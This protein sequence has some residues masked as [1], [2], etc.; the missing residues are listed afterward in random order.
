MT[1]T[2]L[3]K[4]KIETADLAYLVGGATAIIS[5]LGWAEPVFWM[6]DLCSHFRVQYFFILLICGGALAIVRHAKSEQLSAGFLVFDG[7][8]M[9]IGDANKLQYRS[10]P[11]LQVIQVGQLAAGPETGAAPG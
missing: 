4:Q 11:R 7:D 2:S 5:L 8:A 10:Q 1:R 9:D 6:F 3:L